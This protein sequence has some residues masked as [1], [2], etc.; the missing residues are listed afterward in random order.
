M[1]PPFVSCIMAAWNAETTILESVQSVL[2]QSLGD[3]ELI[4][5]DDGST[6]RTPEL[7]STLDDPRLTVQRQPNAGPSAARNH[8]ARLA[9]GE[10][11][12]FIDSDDVWLPDKLL[13][14]L[15]ALEQ[16]LDAAVAYGWTDFVDANLKPLCA[17]DRATYSGSVYKELLAHN[18][19]SSGSNT[20][21]RRD[22]FSAVGGFD[23]TLRAAEDWELHVRLAAGYHFA[24]VP[25]VVVR[26]RRRNDSLSSQ[27]DQTEAHFLAANRKV[28]SHVPVELR[29][30][31]PKS[32][33]SFYR[34]AAV[35]ATQSQPW[36]V[37][38]PRAVRF[39]L[40]AARLDP[41]TFA[42]HFSKPLV[43]FALVAVYFGLFLA[44]DCLMYPLRWDETHYWPTILEFSQEW[45]PKLKLLQ[46][47]GELNTPL[48]FLIMGG[49][50]TLF[51][52][53]PFVG[54][55]INFAM[56]FAIVST[57]A[58]SGPSRRSTLAAIGLL[59][60][61]YYLQVSVFLYTD[62]MAAFFVFAGFWLY[63]NER[64]GWAALAMTMAIAT[65][66]YAVAFPAALALYEF[67]KGVRTEGLR[68][69]WRWLAPL[70]AASSIGF[71][72]LLFG[73][74][75]P[76]G[77][78]ANK[79]LIVPTVQA[80][81]FALDPRAAMHALAGLG[82]YFVIPEWLLLSRKFEWRRLFT[83]KALLIA[84][85][86]LILFVNVSAVESHGLLFKI[87][88]MM[89]VWLFVTVILYIPATI[90]AIRF[91]QPSLALCLVMLQLAI[92]LKAFPWDKY[93]LPLLVVLWYLKSV[94]PE[95]LSPSA[96]QPTSASSAPPR[97]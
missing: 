51:H 67:L 64:H 37:Q 73:G 29:Q 78:F 35:R 61:P 3:L 83:R 6:D 43:A 85:V 59:S 40:T 89:P 60:F 94:A 48:L 68:I 81:Q 19:I 66:Q 26:Y 70:L 56:S 2:A 15:E 42:W 20:L 5:I 8:G 41:R 79:E 75:A 82:I 95:L 39:G 10:Y 74:L 31:E 49:L 86:L 53:G 9:R 28:F 92:M 27:T 84:L 93:L 58:F 12:A 11:L 21:I 38:W 13:R 80:R 55:L 22:A 44:F 65:R 52:G 63:R 62:M 36:H 32:R 71:W 96:S 25:E 69:R 24:Y 4:V 91:A 76:S 72:I 88:K 77:A 23:E 1:K 87:S 33:A 97:E 18:F 50:E 34:Y 30:L 46:T 17:D 14:Q 54:R 57:I 47:Y 45:P 16:S 90:A 7:L